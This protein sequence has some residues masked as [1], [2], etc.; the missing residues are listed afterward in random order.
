MTGDY[1]GSIAW[2]LLLVPF[3]SPRLGPGHLWAAIKLRNASIAE[4]QPASQPKIGGHLKLNWLWTS[5]PL[6]SRSNP[7]VSISKDECSFPIK[8]LK[9]LQ[10]YL[11][12]WGCDPELITFLGTLP[13]FLYL[14]NV[15]SFPGKKKEKPNYKTLHSLCPQLWGINSI[16]QFML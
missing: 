14:E 11:E 4:G 13:Y 5:W 9:V 3:I 15:C 8:V 7:G 10:R 12:F 1:R 16:K 2:I 6:K